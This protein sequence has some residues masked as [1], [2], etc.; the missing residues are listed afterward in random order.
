MAEFSPPGWFLRSRLKMRHIQL[1]AAVDEARSIHKAAARLRMTQPAATKLLAE[2]EHLL[3][4]RLFERS[5]R[6]IIPT[7]HGESLAR[8]AR[9]VLGTLDHARDEMTALKAG[10]TGKLAI[11]ML[12]VAAPLLLPRALLAFKRRNPRVTVQLQEGNLGTLLPRLSRGE[13]DLVVGRLT[14][15]FATT[16]LAF[17]HCYDEP[18]AVV[19]RL[20]HPLRR[21]RNLALADLARESWVLPP[22]EA[23][24]R[25][26]IDA[27]FRR[28]GVDPPAQLVES[29][30]YLANT[31]LLQESDMLGVMPRNVARHY[32][33][34]DALAVLN[35]QLPL[36]SGPVGVITR[37]DH[38]PSAAFEEMLSALRA[39]GRSLAARVR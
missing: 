19:A 4:V 24:F 27:A 17:T 39:A 33:R 34:A 22:P 29:T 38:P 11:G 2:L 31:T 28:G 37:T 13:L 21:R 9:A 20:G 12:L 6:G 23:A 25:Q 3:E 8:H 16:G 35:V 26:R 1:V 15:D 32:A 30:S 5:T 10:A 14:S 36:P 18:M 7:P